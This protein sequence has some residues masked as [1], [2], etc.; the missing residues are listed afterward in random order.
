L[1]K[2]FHPDTNLENKYQLNC[3]KL[4]ILDAC[5]MH[6]YS[7]LMED[8]RLAEAQDLAK[9]YFEAHMAEN[10]SYEHAKKL[11][12]YLNKYE[13]NQVEYLLQELDRTHTQD[14]QS[15]QKE[16]E[17]SLR[18]QEIDDALEKALLEA[19]SQGEAEEAAY[20]RIHKEFESKYQELYSKMGDIEKEEALNS[21]ENDAVYEAI[22]RANQIC[23]ETN[24]DFNTVL[25]EEM[26]KLNIEQVPVNAAENGSEESKNEAGQNAPK[27]PDELITV[28]MDRF[29]F[30]SYEDAERFIDSKGGPDEAL[31]QEDTSGDEDLARRLEGEE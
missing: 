16:E 30:D 4:R 15:V 29:A 6:I 11:I 24:R 13:H 20:D 19:I 28:V 23:Q 14:K 21:N 10:I 25:E 9:G 12:S 22:K 5:V 31:R 26:A 18:K 2:I 3:E 8:G 27:Y 7:K 17:F 1:K